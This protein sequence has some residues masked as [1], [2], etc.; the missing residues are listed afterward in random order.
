M[1]K[2]NVWSNEGSCSSYH[3]AKKVRAIHPHHETRRE[4]QHDVHG[5]AWTMKKRLT[6]DGRC[7]GSRIAPAMH[8]ATDDAVPHT[9]TCRRAGRRRWSRGRS[10]EERGAQPPEVRS[11][12][13]PRR[14]QA[15]R[16]RRRNRRRSVLLRHPRSMQ[17]FGWTTHHLW[18]SGGRW[19]LCHRT[20]WRDASG[21]TRST[22][23]MS[24]G[25][26][27]VNL[28]QSIRRS[29]REELA[30]RAGERAPG[31]ETSGRTDQCS[32][33]KEEAK[34]GCN[35]AVFWRGGRRRGIR[36]QAPRR[37]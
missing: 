8:D 21:R 25:P 1:H 29:R 5:D 19:D 24:A 28:G 16:C 31:R 11:S 37:P 32:S 33:T 30:G 35:L 36:G 12:W 14:C 9:T 2:W 3:T 10:N 13:N 7:D 20:H 17:R 4:Q 26:G 23:G 18:H 15:T 27:R 6:D 34:E 22:L